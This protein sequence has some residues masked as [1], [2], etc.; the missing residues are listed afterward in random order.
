MAGNEEQ[1][2]QDPME[3]ARCILFWGT[4]SAPYFFLHPLE[5]VAFRWSSFPFRHNKDAPGLASAAAPSSSLWGVSRAAAR[6]L[7]L[8]ETQARRNGQSQWRRLGSGLW[9]HP[10]FWS[11]M[12]MLEDAVGWLVSARVMSLWDQLSPAHTGCRGGGGGEEEHG[13]GEGGKLG[14]SRVVCCCWAVGREVVAAAAAAFVVRPLVAVKNRLNCQLPLGDGSFKYTGMLQCFHRTLREE[15]LGGLGYGRRSF[16]P[17]FI[18][19]LSSRLCSTAFRHCRS[20]LMLHTHDR[21]FL[22]KGSAVIANDFVLHSLDFVM[23]YTT[24]QTINMVV[25][26]PWEVITRRLDVSSVYG[27]EERGI[28][29]QDWQQCAKAIWNEEGLRGFYKGAWMAAISEAQ[30]F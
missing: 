6:L 30:K 4:A 17:G 20:S 24:Y 11:R 14:G 15:G 26:W 21:W 12:L 28:A 16:L 10:G 1:E 19:E 3:V 18:G 25:T 8:P 7:L 5:V 13:E 22:P 23:D 2:Q 29:Y 27:G 9:G